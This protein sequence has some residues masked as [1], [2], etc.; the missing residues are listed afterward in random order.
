L[1]GLVSAL[2]DP[3]EKRL[4]G[5]WEGSGTISGEF[6]LEENPDP[7]RKLSGRKISGTVTSESTVQAEFRSDGTYTWHEQH[8][9]PGASKGINAS[10][11]VPKEGGEPARWEVIG[12]R[13]N[14]LS[15][16]L[17]YGEVVFEFQGENAFTMTLPESAHASGTMKF[18][19]SN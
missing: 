8:Q 9:G 4:L 15:V 18:R 12:T 6:S 14:K 13:S 11:R 17:H 19:R 3:L 2:G 1:V 16:R 5:A 10:F 7:A